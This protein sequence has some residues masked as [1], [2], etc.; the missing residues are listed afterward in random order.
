MELELGIIM[1]AAFFVFVLIFIC[2]LAVILGLALVGFSKNTDKI[3][4]QDH[5]QINP[6]PIITYK[7][8]N[9]D[10]IEF[11][12]PAEEEKEIK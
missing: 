2:F 12:E 4:P 10:D 8:I 5:T 1:S 6:R 11:E 9:W 7:P 3:P